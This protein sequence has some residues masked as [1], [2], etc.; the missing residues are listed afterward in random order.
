[1]KKFTWTLKIALVII[2]LSACSQTKEIGS[3]QTSE[4]VNTTEISENVDDATEMIE[5][6]ITLTEDY[7][8]EELS[9]TDIYSGEYC[10]YEVNDP[11][12]EIKKMMTEPIKFK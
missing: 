1:M 12:L 5:E 7:K 9:V 2:A 11:S 4:I 3:M 6:S 10:D 8:E